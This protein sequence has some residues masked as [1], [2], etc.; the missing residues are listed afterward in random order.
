MGKHTVEA[1]KTSANAPPLGRAWISN[2]R[3]NELIDAVLFAVLF[4]AVV[5]ASESDHPTVS[6]SLRDVPIGEA[7]KICYNANI[8]AFEKNDYSFVVD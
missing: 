3:P 8:E 2:A 1:R 6:A 4:C 5:A 7:I